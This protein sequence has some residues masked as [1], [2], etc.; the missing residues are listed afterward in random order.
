VLLLVVQN[1]AVNTTLSV[2]LGAA[3]CVWAATHAS[4][5]RRVV[6]GLMLRLFV[7][8]AMYQHGASNSRCA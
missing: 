6:L 2:V 5:A 4:V 8:H 1:G 7:G 3:S